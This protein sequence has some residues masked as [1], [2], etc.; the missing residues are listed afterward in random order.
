[1]Q[2]SSFLSHKHIPLS[3][4]PAQDLL[5]NL[6]A[7]CS[8]IHH[9]LHQ[10]RVGSLL[11]YCLDGL[12][13]APS[14]AIPYFIQA[15]DLRYDAALAVVGAAKPN[16]LLAPHFEDQLRIWGNVDCCIYD[17]GGQEKLPYRLWKMS[18]EDVFKRQERE[19]KEL[20]KEVE[21]D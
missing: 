8:F 5:T 21:V 13:L 18:L 3:V 4:L 1:M 11:V 16:G 10:D 12:N 14:I 7:A 6:E 20:R 15:K 17:S 9:N 2:H 19:L